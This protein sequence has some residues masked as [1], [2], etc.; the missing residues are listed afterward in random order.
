MIQATRTSVG[1]TSRYSA[2]PPQTPAIFLFV[3]ERGSLLC[4]EGG[5]NIAAPQ[6]QQKLTFSSYSLPHCGQYM[7][8]TSPS[9]LDTLIYVSCRAKV[10]KRTNVIAD[11]PL[12]TWGSREAGRGAE[13]PSDI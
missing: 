8:E 11:Q 9:T 5:V 3:L 2:T 7:V 6:W 12:C 13:I 10:S 1:S 4:G